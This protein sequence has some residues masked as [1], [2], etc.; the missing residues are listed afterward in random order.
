MSVPK[1]L[2]MGLL[3]RSVKCWSLNHHSCCWRCKDWDRQRSQQ[4]LPHWQTPDAAADTVSLVTVPTP[5]RGFGGVGGR[6]G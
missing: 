1:A 6:G 4:T 3:S 2:L 5:A